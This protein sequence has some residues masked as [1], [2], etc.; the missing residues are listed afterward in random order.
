MSTESQIGSAEED[1]WRRTLQQIP[2]MLGKLAYLS[3]LRNTETDRYEHFGLSAVFGTDAAEV[4][5][6]SSHLDLLEQWLALPLDR[7]RV[8][9]EEYLDSLPQPFLKSVNSWLRTA[10]YIQFLPPQRSNAQQE[11]YMA[12]LLLLLRSFTSAQ[13]ELGSGPKASQR[14]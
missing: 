1:L 13:G 8:D 4:A 3:K 10:P 7:Q 6:R 2:T 5:M 9:L 14:P 12:N 11:L